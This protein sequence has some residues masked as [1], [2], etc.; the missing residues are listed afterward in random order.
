[1]AARGS[2]IYLEDVTVNFDGFKALSRLNFFMDRRELRVVIGPNGAG[3]TTLLDVVS[4]RVKPE[5]G[6]ARD[7]RRQ[8][9]PVAAARE[10][11]RPAWHRPQVPDA[12]GVREPHGLGQRRAV[13]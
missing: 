4:R 3:K 10:R 11:D 9:R 5:S 13:A 7:R 12:L 6:R 2:I 1:M 8:R